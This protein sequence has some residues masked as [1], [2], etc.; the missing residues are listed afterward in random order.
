MKKGN[1]K[2]SMLLVTLTLLLTLGT[3]C[4]EL[5]VG[6]GLTSFGLGYL[7]ASTAPT[8]TQTQCFVN[9]EEVDCAALPE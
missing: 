6:G 7:L 2:F 3:G 4:T 1:V 9:G 5:L 8:V